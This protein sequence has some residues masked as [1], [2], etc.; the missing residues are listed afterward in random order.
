MLLAAVAIVSTGVS[1]DGGFQFTSPSDGDTWELGTAHAVAWAYGGIG[2]LWNHTSIVLLYGSDSTELFSTA[3]VR[4]QVFNWTIPNDLAPGAYEMRMDL[5][6]H[7]G[8]VIVAD[9]TSFNIVVPD[10]TPPTVV[11]S[12]PANGE[13]GIY[14]EAHMHLNFSEPMD[15]TSVEEAFTLSL[16]GSP[17]AGNFSYWTSLDRTVFFKSTLNLQYSTEYTMTVGTGAKD[18]AG[19]YLAEPFTS[20]FTTRADPDLDNTPPIISAVSPTSP[21]TLYTSMAS[22]AQTF[23]ASYSDNVGVTDAAVT[24]D[25]VDVSSAWGVDIS[26]FSHAASLA[27]GQHTIVLMI[28]DAAGNQAQHT[29]TVDVVADNVG[30]TI[31]GYTDEMKIKTAQQTPWITASFAD[32]SGINVA[33][34]KVY[35]DGKD[36]TSKAIITETGIQYP[37]ALLSKSNHLFYIQAYDKAGNLATASWHVRV[38]DT[39]KK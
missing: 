20:T 21:L 8:S 36:V 34:V 5:V 10:T 16:G 4:E 1:A 38:G 13:S 23:S 18:L 12:F 11:N 6:L 33:S 25:G 15:W 30:P 37:T 3:N 24:M 9:R 17:I 26:G 28:K 32:Q 7:D 2:T 29:W 19:N 31:S 27:I 35:V 39:Y 22:T 14:V